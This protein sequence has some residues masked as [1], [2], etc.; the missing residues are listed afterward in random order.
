MSSAERIRAVGM[1]QNKVKKYKKLT[2]SRGFWLVVSFL[3]AVNLWV[4]VT[5]TE[6]VEGEKTLSGVKI[7][8]LGAESLRESSGLIITE[9]DRTTVNLTVK[10]ARR[11]LGK[12][13]SSNVTAAVDLSRVTTD[14][15]NS[16]SYE[17][18]YPSGVRSDDV[19]VL[20]SSSDIVNFYVDRQ[21]RKTIPVQGEFIGSTAEGYMAE[22]EPV[23]DPMMVIISGPK[24]AIEPVDHA[25]VAISRTDVDKTL[26]FNT[27]YALQDADGQEI[28]D[29]RITLETSEVAVTLNV[30]FTKSVP[31]DVTIIDGGG[32]TR[33]ENTKIT[34]NPASI[35]LSG[36]AAVIE[37]ISK[38]N[39]GTISLAD[40]ASTYTDTYTIVPPNDTENLTGIKEASVTVSIVGLSTRIFEITNDNI[41]CTNVPDGYQAVIINQVLPVTVRAKESDLNAIHVNNIRA[42]ADL[43]GISEANATGVFQPEVRISIDGFPDAG[44]VEEYRI[45][46]TLAKEEE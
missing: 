34:I 20:R 24:T 28:D 42:V 39:L 41:Y 38:I 19:T 4:Y 29:P 15:W 30:L 11:V 26:Q 32:A 7:E 13:S 1:S 8:F 14:G 45:Y 10:A 18:I 16:V 27:T 9:Q 22:D 6:G 44:I 12:L 25:Y 23:F 2:E 40:F 35:V 43:S 3:V 21:S 5:T 37:S 36:D 46:V 33:A 31:L 17:I